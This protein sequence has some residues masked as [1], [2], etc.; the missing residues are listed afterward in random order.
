MEG[1]AGIK[2]DYKEAL[3]LFTLAS[4][5]ENGLGSS[6]IAYVYEEAK[7]VEKIIKRQQSII[8][9]QLSKVRTKLY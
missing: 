4:E 2:Q 1:K 7:G 6:N 9:S 3:R 5:A 8:H